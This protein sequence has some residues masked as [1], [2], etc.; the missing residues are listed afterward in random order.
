MSASRDIE[1]RADFCD[2]EVILGV[3]YDYAPGEQGSSPSLSDPGDPGWGPE[4]SITKIEFRSITE[5]R[6][7]AIWDELSRA[8]T[9]PKP[10]EAFGNWTE[11]TGPLFDLLA[12]SQWIIDQIVEREDDRHSSYDPED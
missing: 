10:K 4:V 11:I 6:Q 7:S 3:D 8:F 5:V 12:D 1:F 9:Y 2:F